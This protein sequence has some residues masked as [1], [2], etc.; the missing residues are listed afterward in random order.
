MPFRLVLFLLFLGGIS[1]E[2]K[3][4]VSI[5]YPQEFDKEKY[6]EAFENEGNVQSNH[7]VTIKKEVET[8]YESSK[9][10]DFER[11]DT[12]PLTITYGRAKS[13]FELY[14]GHKTI[15][16]FDTDTALRFRFKLAPQEDSEI[17][18]SIKII[19]SKGKETNLYELE[20]TYSI[21]ERGGHS[22]EVLR[23]SEKEA[24]DSDVYSFDIQLI[25]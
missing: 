10:I 12:L 22:I 25:W 5:A 24:T 17:V 23:T 4:R 8:I 14:N 1:C 3:P 16:V 18:P 11:V 13:N 20:A 7:E 2:M 15:F 19:N 6:K 9:P 21:E